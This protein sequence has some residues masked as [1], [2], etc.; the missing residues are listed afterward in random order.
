MQ[1]L[2]YVSESRIEHTDVDSEL[3]KIVDYSQ[4]KNVQLGITGALL[5][6]GKHFAQ[7]LEGPPEAIHILMAFIYNDPRHTNISVV[8][9]SPITDRRF[10]DWQMAYQGPSQFVSRHVARLMDAT[11]QSQRQRAVDWITDLAYE[12]SIPL[13]LPKYIKL[14][15]SR[16]SR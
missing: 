11:S 4:V 7:V 2:I 6:T 8:D 15:S 13:N 10:A 3:A 14:V 9:R 1:R 12:F 16:P 5:F